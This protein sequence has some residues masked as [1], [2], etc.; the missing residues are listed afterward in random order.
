MD[1]G[2]WLRSLGLEQYETTFRDHAIDAEILLGLTDADLITLGLPL[3]HRKRLL[4]AIADLG[5]APLPPTEAPRRVAD[6]AAPPP[7]AA[8]RRQIT[9][10]FYDLVGSTA[11]SAQLDAEDWRNLVETYLQ[12]AV[13]AVTAMGGYVAKKLGDGLMAL[14]GYPV[15]RENDPERAARAA[16]AIQ[17]AIAA[18][19]SAHAGTDKPALMARVG[20][21]SGLVVV[22]S[23]GEV[24]GEA[25]NVAARVQALAEPGGVLTTA[26]VQGQLAG[27]FVVEDRGAHKLKGM[28]AP[29]TLYQLV[30]QSGATRRL[31]ARNLTPL[32]GRQE[33]LAAIAKRWKRAQRGT[34]QLMLVVGDPGLGKSRLVEEFRQS[35]G[36]TAH[37]WIEWSA[38]QLL[39]NTALHPYTEW[40]R[41]RFDANEP[42]ERRLAD[43]EATLCQVGLDPAE[44]APLLAPALDIP[45]PERR[46]A[47]ELSPDAFRRRQLE[48]MIAWMLVSARTQPTALVVEDL[49][50]ADPTTLELLRGLAERGAEA[51]LM[52]LTTARPEFRA[53]WSMRAHH[54]ALALQPLEEDEVRQMVGK[55]AAQQ[56]LAREMVAHVAARTGGVPLF[57]EEVTRLLLEHPELANAAAIPPTL[58]QS[59]TARLDRLGPAREVAQIAA[60]LGREF[61]FDLLSV[62]ADGEA[63]MLGEALMRLVDADL[64][65][66]HGVPPEADYRFK[67]ALI[68]DAAYE[69]L[70]KSR[71]Q[72]LHGR[73]AEAL[74]DHFLARAQA[75]PEIVAHHFTQAGQTDAAIEWWGRAGDQ[76]LRRSA[77]QEAI[78]HLGKAIEM[79]DR[80]AAVASRRETDAMS[81]RVKLQTDYGQAVMWSKGFAAEETKAAFARVQELAAQGGESRERFSAYYAQCVG[82]LHRGDLALARKTAERFHND[83][84]GVADWTST[85]AAGRVLGWICFLQGDLREARARL[86]R[87]VRTYDAERDR[88]SRHRFGTDTNVGALG[89]LAMIAWQLGE[90]EEARQQLDQAVA[91][92][93]AMDHPPTLVNTRHIRTIFE[94]ARGDPAAARRDAAAIAHVSKEHGMELFE[95]W[96]ALALAWTEGR[97]DDRRVGSRSLGQA[98]SNYAALGMRSFVPLYEGLRAELDA[99]GPSIDSAVTR[100][101]AAVGFAAKTGERWTD[102][103]LHRIR[104]EIL[105]KRDPT[106]PV[107]AE[108]AL[109]TAVAVA[110]EQGARSLGLLAALQ[111][112]RLYHATARRVEA[113]A[114]LASALEGFTPTPEMPEISE[115]RALL[116]ALAETKEVKAAAAQRKR[117][118]ELQASYGLAVMWSKGFATQEATA[119]WER[120]REL[121]AAEAGEAWVRYSAYHAQSA[122]SWH[123][124]DLRF[125][126]EMAER[127]L[128]DAEGDAN[129]TA[130][131]AANRNLGWICFLQGEFPEARE[132]FEH[133]ARTYD[134]ERDGE[135]RH[136]FGT[137]AGVSAEGG[138]ASVAWQ[139]GEV[140]EARRLLNKTTTRAV[141]L[142]HPPTLVY[143]HILG[144]LSEII[145]GDAAAA[146][147]EAS[148]A[149]D[150][151]RAHGMGT[152]EAWSRLML[153][154]TRGRLED[155]EVGSKNLEQ[156]LS[157]YVARGSRGLLPLFEG[158]KAQLDA[159]GPSIEAALTMIDDALDLSA[160]TGEHWT[161]AMLHRIRGEILL[162][163][164]PSNAAL[165]EQALLTAIAIARQQRARSF[166]LLAALTLAKIYYT[167]AR[168]AEASAVLGPALEGFSAT[169]EMPA[170]AEARNL[171]AAVEAAQ[172]TVGA[173][174]S[175]SSDTAST[176]VR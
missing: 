17:G 88:E 12:A 143:I 38:S 33:E 164:D 166:G 56:A 171:L 49:H 82:S 133:A 156:A 154:W 122:G 18:L 39:Q 35:L 69:S 8:E 109:Q 145:R 46:K 31:S 44:H 126:R 22:D 1:V 114:L 140:N 168:L 5:A 64:L 85:S 89:V 158:L 65:H 120:V 161:D 83:A 101:D 14:F 176:A 51:P 134:A 78:A 173:T 152:S 73:A 124:G 24:Y 160:R 129:M 107:P 104:G 86:R 59:L 13:Q 72:A 43:L 71:R 159:E 110:R 148:V 118:S 142:A 47:T 169:P 10:M 99:E 52:I 37:T 94:I 139:L 157:A 131:T 36:T 2:N 111:L 77:F 84:E 7:H 116:A 135:S 87:A 48:A 29:V 50:W 80:A 136:H 66:V 32:V 113:H 92:A 172:R 3:G 93:V 163:H 42:A 108:E 25:P 21:A 100:I 62:L 150:L 162:K 81:Q 6:A 149:A 28:S 9:V 95:A 130:V 128:A 119:A 4:K 132:H 175:T 63:S 141:A 75:G 45:L 98:L 11:L 103:I 151:S 112:A 53:P 20:I 117:R 106:N 115:A 55:I 79:A 165:A 137:D 90:I 155:H 146:R 58:Q 167:S 16:L 60:V 105:L 147:S 123:S 61:S 23:S 19:N 97:L 91:G 138:L 27:L 174:R 54:G 68:R 127:F 102:A 67:H 15:A 26:D 125:A 57:I 30:R 76:A 121:A 170:I 40:G 144:A 41:R 74:R 70:L 34:G 153:A 96:S